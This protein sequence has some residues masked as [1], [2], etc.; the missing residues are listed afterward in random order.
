[1][2]LKMQNNY[3]TLEPKP[4]V[5]DHNYQS[6]YSRYMLV[7]LFVLVLFNLHSRF[8]PLLIYFICVILTSTIDQS[9]NFWFLNYQCLIKYKIYDK[10]NKLKNISGS[11]YST[12]IFFNSFF[13]QFFLINFIKIFLLNLLIPKQ[14]NKINRLS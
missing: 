8:R 12:N 3:N 11:F 13:N 4:I 6:N 9:Y 10:I 2:L 7:E 1:M 5:L 14:K